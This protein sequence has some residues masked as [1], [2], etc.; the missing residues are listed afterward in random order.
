MS[1]GLPPSE[2]YHNITSTRAE[3]SCSLVK[4][5]SVALWPEVAVQDHAYVGGDGVQH[6][7]KPIFPIS[8]KFPARGS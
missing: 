7:A 1:L 5:A 3:S 6:F 4:R 8:A 2:V